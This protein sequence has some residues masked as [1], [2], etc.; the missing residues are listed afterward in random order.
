MHRLRNVRSSSAPGR[1]QQIRGRRRLIAEPSGQGDARDGYARG[2][3]GQDGAAGEIDRCL[4]SRA[5]GRPA[6]RAFSGKAVPSVN[7]TMPLGQQSTQSMHS[8]QASGTRPAVGSRASMRQTAAHW[9]HALQTLAGIRF[10]SDRRASRPTSAPAGHRYRHQNRR[11]T[12][13]RAK[14]VVRMYRRHSGQVKHHWTEREQ[15]FLHPRLQNARHPAVANPAEARIRSAIEQRIGPESHSAHQQRKRID[16]ADQRKS[17]HGGQQHRDQE[18]V[19]DGFRGG[20][21]D[22]NFP[23][24][25]GAGLGVRVSA[26]ASKQESVVL[27][28]AAFTLTLSQRERGPPI[29]CDARCG[30]NNPGGF[31]VGRPNRKRTG[32]KSSSIQRP[33]APARTAK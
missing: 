2:D 27:V 16:V 11:A 12:N 17:E 31:P 26:A 29:R 15:V 14:I 32:R 13:S 19:L 22:V 30:G 24:P 23:L 4:R 9:P 33:P 5:A 6:D 25:L 21:R 20:N 10:T 8:V 3:A 18:K 28:Q 7:L 1:T